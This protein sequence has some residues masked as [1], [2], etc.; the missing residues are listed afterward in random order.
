MSTITAVQQTHLL[1]DDNRGIF[2]MIE[3]VPA[4]V[5]LDLV[6]GSSEGMKKTRQQR[7][8]LD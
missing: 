8:S 4:A 2:L 7:V 6:E 5:I 3:S 1:L